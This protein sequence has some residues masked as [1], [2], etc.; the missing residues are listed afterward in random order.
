MTE[1]DLATK[2][3][4]FFIQNH[5]LL[6]TTTEEKL[7]TA[8][9]DY[10]ASSA[11][12]FTKPVPRMENPKKE[13]EK[14]SGL[15]YL[16]EK[17]KY[18]NFYQR[19]LVRS[20]TRRIATISVPV[21]EEM[22]FMSLVKLEAVQLDYINLWAQQ[23]ASNYKINIWMDSGTLLAGELAERLQEV[24][25]KHSLNAEYRSNEAF[26]THLMEWQ[27]RAYK[28][29]VAKMSLIDSSKKGNQKFS[30][31]QAVSF[32]LED[33]GLAKPGEL[34]KI[35]R[36][37]A[38]SFHISVEKL[39]KSI[40]H[41]DRKNINLIDF[42]SMR[43]QPHYL[44]YIREL[45]SR[46]NLLAATD[47][48]RLMLLQEHGGLYLDTDVLPT[49]NKWLF[50]LVTKFDSAGT[51]DTRNHEVIMR[52]ILDELTERGKMPGRAAV[53][54]SENHGG[55]LDPLQDRSPHEIRR[56]RKWVQLVLDRG[57]SPFLP[58]N[59]LTVDPLFQYSYANGNNKAVVAKKDS[60]FIN[61]LLTN[62]QQ[63]HE[64]MDKHHV[65]ELDYPI[66]Q[67]TLN[68]MT[69]ELKAKGL[70]IHADT[71]F[72]YRS[73]GAITAS[74]PGTDQVAGV[75]TYHHAYSSLLHNQDIASDSKRSL[76][77]K[78]F[79]PFKRAFF[80]TEEAHRSRLREPGMK[81]PHYVSHHKSNYD[82]QY[83]IQLQDDASVNQM[84]RFLYNKNGDRTAHYC[85]TQQH[86]RLVKVNAKPNFAF[87]GKTRI[88][89]IGH[90]SFMRT[91]GEEKIVQL[92]VDANLLAK[93]TSGAF[94]A[95]DRVSL[96]ACNLTES[97]P[98]EANRPVQQLTVEQPSE[99]FV[100]RLYRTFSAKKIKVNSI[101][102]RDNL[103]TV[104]VLGRK[105]TGVPLNQNAPQ[106]QWYIQWTLVKE[107]SKKLI[108]TQQDDG[109][110]VSERILET[111][112]IAA[113]T[114][115]IH[116][117]YSGRFGVDYMIKVPDGQKVR[118][119]GKVDEKTV[120][121]LMDNMKKGQVLMAPDCMALVAGMCEGQGIIVNGSERAMSAWQKALQLTKDHDDY[122]SWLAALD[123]SSGT[124]EL[125]FCMEELFP[126]PEEAFMR[127][128]ER[129]LHDE[130]DLFCL[131]LSD[132][133][134][135]GIIDRDIRKKG[136]VRGI[137]LGSVEELLLNTTREVLKL[138][139]ELSVH[140]SKIQRALEIIEGN[141]LHLS[142]GRSDTPLYYR[143]V[144]IKKSEAATVGV[145]KLRRKYADKDYLTRLRALSN[146]PAF[147]TL[148]G[149]PIMLSESLSQANQ[150]LLAENHLPAEQWSPLLSATRHDKGY[151]KYVV[152]YLHND[153]IQEK[154]LLTSSDEFAKMKV[155]LDQ[156][157]EILAD[158]Y[159]LTS[160]A[161]LIQ[162]KF[163]SKTEI[164]G[165]GVNTVFAIMAIQHWLRNGVTLP[166]DTPLAN[167]LQVHT[168]VAMTQVG[169]NA[170]SD[171]VSSLASLQNAFLRRQILQN[172][173]A[174]T[175]LKK[176]GL[177]STT[178]SA[179]ASG[180]TVLSNVVL[181][182]TGFTAFSRL[183]QLI[184]L[185]VGLGL[186]IADVV[187]STIELSKAESEG[188]RT[189]AITQLS[190]SAAGLSL[191]IGSVIAGLLG[192]AL[193]VTGLFIVG[194]ALA[195]AGFF[196]QQT[197][198]DSLNEAEKVRFIIDYFKNMFTGWGKGGFT[199]QRG[200]FVPCQGVVVKQLDLRN[201]D[202]I[203]VIFNEEGQQLR[204]NKEIFS[205]QPYLNL[206]RL[207][208]THKTVTTCAKN[209]NVADITTLILPNQPRAKINTL[210]ECRILEKQKPEKLPL[211]PHTDP[212]DRGIYYLM[213]S[214]LRLNY[215]L[216]N[217]EILLGNNQYHLIAPGIDPTQPV[218]SFINQPVYAKDLHYWLRAPEQGPATA[219]LVL[220]RA[221]A[222]MTIICAN[223]QV[224]WIIDASHI[225]AI[226]MKNNAGAGR[227]RTL[228]FVRRILKTEGEYSTEVITT[229][230]LGNSEKT[231]ISVR[232]PQ[233]TIK[234][235]DN[236]QSIFY[237]V[238]VA[239]LNVDLSHPATYGERVKTALP[240]YLQQQNRLNNHAVNYIHL[241]DYLHH[242][243]QGNAEKIVGCFYPMRQERST[244][245]YTAN[246]DDTPFN[247]E[248]ARSHVELI[249]HNENFAWYRGDITLT[250]ERSRERAGS[251]GQLI[252]PVPP[253][254][255]ESSTYENVF[256]MS[257]NRTKKL[258][259]LYLPAIHLPV[260]NHTT[261]MVGRPPAALSEI[262]QTQV[263]AK[264]ILFQHRYTYH[265]GEMSSGY[266]SQQI[267]LIC[268]IDTSSAE[269][270]MTLLEARD[271]PRNLMTTLSHSDSLEDLH[272][273][274][275]EKTVNSSAGA[276][277]SSLH[278]GHS[279]IVKLGLP[280]TNTT[281]SIGN[282]LIWPLPESLHGVTGRI[283]AK[284]DSAILYD[285]RYLTTLAGIVKGDSEDQHHYFWSVTEPDN[286]QQFYKLYLQKGQSGAREIELTDFGLIN[287]QIT[288]ITDCHQ[289][290]LISMKQGQGYYLSVDEQLC[291]QR[292]SKTW[293]SG[294]SH[295]LLS[296]TAYVGELQAQQGTSFSSESGQKKPN[297]NIDNVEKLLIMTTSEQKNDRECTVD[298]QSFSYKEIQLLHR[299][300]GSLHCRCRCSRRHV[301]ILRMGMDLRLLIA[302]KTDT[303][304]VDKMVT[305][306][307]VFDPQENSAYSRLQLSFDEGQITA[308]VLAS[309]HTSNTTAESDQS[310]E[311]TDIFL[312]VSIVGLSLNT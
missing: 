264:G 117:S 14:L 234:K 60:F 44:L 282:R 260:V 198:V 212:V 55:Y 148:F 210:S 156:Q 194:I 244:L 73:E 252:R 165:M 104:D 33:N 303:E 257:N 230:T 74:I 293:H 278:P 286:Q 25:I 125:T 277:F 275:K 220:N 92:L 301:V 142:G 94:I 101:S 91:M 119:S 270:S 62:L 235:L 280:Q 124:T 171:S 192:L 45:A 312:P 174:F 196:I 190:F 150:A 57:D 284:I 191:F 295:W 179:P 79:F 26:K 186:G 183:F 246:H 77:R 70:L 302:D 307:A 298:L 68:T 134:S 15:L 41:R 213:P 59:K 144:I 166:S 30:F 28:S 297:L 10:L 131:D 123:L 167:I 255:I 105:W 271:L 47:I 226:E 129:Y 219:V 69:T 35:R 6:K 98:I 146:K 65:G 229:I 214:E 211:L 305:I 133:Q 300:A 221:Q 180:S 222:N 151:G 175:A 176:M 306:K 254:V 122:L 64:V 193:L 32:F 157:Q 52:V 251:R 288:N 71:L 114:R 113:R 110:I 126:D 93:D 83:I 7:V 120:L 99:G 115:K 84:A 162:N 152:P 13:M 39:K 66:P 283:D 209:N 181:N 40:P 258:C 2:I 89:L 43:D 53:I 80:L 184:A 154:E 54:A 78:I 158:Y 147:R 285:T 16:L 102:A 63:I 72:C 116:S 272:R 188:Q 217:V 168:Y 309:Y 276:R 263:F 24:A 216:T 145:S 292:I 103:V 227:S 273:F 169:F 5:S 90:G 187:L 287:T 208:D 153:G 143:S 149:D 18:S 259:K 233:G 281:V 127:L 88:I 128:K 58:L 136:A 155:F 232:L 56:I 170:T 224:D 237:R 178:L 19:N 291:L 139:D 304:K 253:T 225:D 266:V 200:V 250:L 8:L 202:Y 173:A 236:Q 37:N 111:K 310:T 267:H 289:G 141:L 248:I 185:P 245:L 61:E 11:E 243:N 268:M 203:S 51:T 279:S 67:E 46:G 249:F 81:S 215:L 182:K 107:S 108:F 242:D 140:Q 241:D 247:S 238:N 50:S 85:Y 172:R 75:S 12:R 135:A 29:I 100:E 137:D 22:H 160:N 17:S 97:T 42:Y 38:E 87:N 138:E 199:L 163:F 177:N 308:N 240:H 195:V 159:H 161:R 76:S 4:L 112:D 205:D 269:G 106:N 36:A 164:I 96:V 265:T 299:G 118:L 201:P 296:L 48:S 21:P 239:D 23:N 34:E 218:H 95:V 274:M 3:S 82:S 1:S 228:K 132:P 86:Q 262:T 197:V 223:K 20:I 109:K 121:R 294:D 206:Y 261:S 49:F 9:V 231:Q 130:F 31:D 204:N 290:V 311:E 207:R 189:L 256:W 27:S